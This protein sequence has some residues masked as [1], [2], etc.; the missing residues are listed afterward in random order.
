MENACQE[1]RVKPGI[2]ETVCTVR[3]RAERF[4]LHE[5]Q[6]HRGS[7]VQIARTS[8]VSQ[9]ALLFGHRLTGTFL[10]ISASTTQPYE[11]VIFSVNTHHMSISRRNLL[12]IYYTLEIGH[13]HIP[14]FQPLYT[15]TVKFLRV[16][17]S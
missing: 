3:R 15:L 5:W 11:R 1:F 10:L 12:P 4:F 17:L 2:F 14:T 9:Q 13:I 16:Q 6:P 8:P 7:A